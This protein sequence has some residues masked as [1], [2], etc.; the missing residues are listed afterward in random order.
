MTDGK[1]KLVISGN[2]LNAIKGFARDRFLERNKFGAGLDAREV[3]ILLIIE[4]FSD[5]LLSQG[6]DPPFKVEV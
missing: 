2:S 1:I 4:G 6:I 5:F 3:Q